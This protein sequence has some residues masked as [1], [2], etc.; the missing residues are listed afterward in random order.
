MIKKLLTPVIRLHV[1]KSPIVSKG[2][3]VTEKLTYGQE[4]ILLL[5]YRTRMTTPISREAFENN[6]QKA[7]E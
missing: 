1:N 6:S 3:F 7:N 2:L 4:Y 5:V